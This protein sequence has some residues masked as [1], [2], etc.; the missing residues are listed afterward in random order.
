MIQNR[1]LVE[2]GGRGVFTKELENALARG[3]IDLAV[4]SLKDLPTILPDEL[5]LSAVL[6]REDVRDAV[7]FRRDL[8]QANLSL[9][10]LPA[11]SI[12]GTSSSRRFAQLKNSRSDIQLKDVRGNVD[13]RLKKLDDGNYTAIMLAV[14]GLK[15]LGYE[16][17]ISVAL[18]VDEM[19]P[20]VGQG[21]LGLETRGEDAETNEFVAS[22]NDAKTWACVTAER[23]FLRGLGGG[24]QFPIAALGVIENDELH[25]R[26]LVAALDGAT[27]LRGAHSGKAAN[28]QQAGVELAQKLLAQGAFD[29]INQKHDASFI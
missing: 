8:H 19:L 27:I 11:N 23:A 3:E 10:D 26:G 4:H 5:C 28:P 21:A 2:I 9:A 15:R 17:R 1:S 12:V 20:Q 22:L 18:S 25:L 13:T 29:L 6:P 24:C 14:A 16:H 7:I